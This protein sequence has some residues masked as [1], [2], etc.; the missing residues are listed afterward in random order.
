MLSDVPYYS[1]CIWD[2]WKHCG[3]FVDNETKKDKKR[4]LKNNCY[5]HVLH[6]A[7]C[8]LAVL[9]LYVFEAVEHYWLEE[10]LSDL[11]SAIICHVR[12]IDEA[13]NSQE[14]V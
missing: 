5:F 6:L 1:S 12:A 7:I 2:S 9:L 8:D 4:L 14:W 10:P 11:S 3:Y 13:F